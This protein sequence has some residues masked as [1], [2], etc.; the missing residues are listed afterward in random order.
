MAPGG[1]VTVTTKQAA[2]PPYLHLCE[3]AENVTTP[4]FA[5]TDN[6]HIIN[7]PVSVLLGS[8]AED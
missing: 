8:S 2:Y 6:Y 1:N 5:L 7:A 4:W 3:V